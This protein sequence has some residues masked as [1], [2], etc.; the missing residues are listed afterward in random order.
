MAQQAITSCLK[1]RWATSVQSGGLWIV[2]SHGTLGSMGC[3]GLG[4]FQFLGAVGGAISTVAE[5]ELCVVWGKLLKTTL[6]F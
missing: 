4:T 6:S 3:W 5:R 1:V 2:R